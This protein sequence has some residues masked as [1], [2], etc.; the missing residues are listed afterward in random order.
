[1]LN[2]IPLSFMVIQVGNNFCEFSRAGHIK[3]E[4]GLNK[5]CKLRV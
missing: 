1:M 2:L 5:D 3:P 4:S